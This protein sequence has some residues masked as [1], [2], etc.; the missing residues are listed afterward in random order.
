MWALSLAATQTSLSILPPGMRPMPIS[1]ALRHI[2]RATDAHAGARMR[3]AFGMMEQGT[4]AVQQLARADA[5]L[6]HA[7]HAHIPE[8]V[9]V[10]IP[11]Y[12]EFLQASVGSVVALL[13][14]LFARQESPC[15][16]VTSCGTFS[17][18]TLKTSLDSYVTVRKPLSKVAPLLDPR[19]WA[20]C[21][22]LFRRTCQVAKPA[23]CEPVCLPAKPADLGTDW[24]G[25]LYERAVVGYQEVENLLSIDLAACDVGT[26]KGRLK[27][28]YS[29]YRSISHRFGGWEFP[30][31]MRNNSGTI[32]ATAV[33]G[34]KDHQP[35]E[36]PPHTRIRVTKLVHYGRA[37]SWSGTSALDVGELCNY[38][39]PAFLTLWVA[40]VKFVVPCCPDRDR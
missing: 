31:L 35:D 29:L 32:T 8:V 17:G 36:E 24:K 26:A 1:E 28:D 38:L 9:I 6:F 10:A 40:N 21:S 16:D 25:E 20:S 37:G 13:K 22:D 14:A 15:F 18:N 7:E 5:D 33:A 34:G 2:G 19:A 27:I 23:G 4:A 30:G 3:M 12:A 11:V 39:A